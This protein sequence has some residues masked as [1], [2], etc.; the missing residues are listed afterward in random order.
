MRSCLKTTNSWAWWYIPLI[1][2]RTPSPA[3]GRQR[4]ADL[5]EFKASFVYIVSSRTA[6][7][8]Q[9]D[10]VSKITKQNK[11]TEKTNKPRRTKK[12]R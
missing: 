4:Q 6:R 12:Q 8:V 9:R 10:P 1:P 2:T 5:C 11:Q 3:L 7:A